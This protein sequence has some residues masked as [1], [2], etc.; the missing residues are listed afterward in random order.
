M[1]KSVGKTGINEEREI[2]MRK[3]NKKTKQKKYL[4]QNQSQ[5]EK[6]QEKLLKN[7]LWYDMI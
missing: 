7:I 2:Y 1:F 6:N 4:Q 3:M 5:V